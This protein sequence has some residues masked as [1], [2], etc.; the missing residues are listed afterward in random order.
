MTIE[1]A[2]NKSC[3]HEKIPVF[4]SVLPTSSPAGLTAFRAKA[5]YPL[6]DILT[7]EEE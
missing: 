1:T 7:Q 2:F 5:V 4:I 6:P 3:Y